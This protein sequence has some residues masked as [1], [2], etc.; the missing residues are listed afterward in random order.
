MLESAKKLKQIMLKI[1]N[2]LG[3]ELQEFKPAEDVRALLELQGK[4]DRFVEVENVLAMK[5][6]RI[7]EQDPSLPYGNG[8]PI[9]SAKEFLTPGEPFLMLFGDDMFTETVGS[10]GGVIQLLEYFENSD[11]EGVTA[12]ERVSEDQAMKGAI[13]KPLDGNPDA[14]EGQV[15]LILE[16]P[17]K[18][19]LFSTLFS[20]SP[21]ILPYRVFDFLGVENVGKDHELWLQDANN[22]LAHSGKYMYKVLDGHYMTT[23]DPTRYLAV[24]LE[25]YL[26][27]P[28]Y[29]AEA[30]EIIKQAAA[31]TGQQ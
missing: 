16:K 5:N 24:Q 31:R 8:S 4:M 1:Y 2:T 25:Y 15:E 17:S 14:N 19:E 10:K 29:G 23:G 20:F 11:A 3:R 28:K 6:V 27:H 9:V 26:R 30:A 22:K 7:I 13:V 12:V 21:M 18:E